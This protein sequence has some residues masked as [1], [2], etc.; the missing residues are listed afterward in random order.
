MKTNVKSLILKSLV[1]CVGLGLTA[2]SSDEVVVN[3]SESTVMNGKYIPSS[4]AAQMDRLVYIDNNQM[5]FEFYYYGD[6]LYYNLYHFGLNQELPI[7]AKAR[8]PVTYD[9]QKSQS[10]W[11]LKLENRRYF[12]NQTNMHLISSTGETLY[13]Q[14][15][16]LPKLDYKEIEITVEPIPASGG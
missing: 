16:I 6:K 10:T 13:P 1:L 8:V 2:C 9:I 15:V 7:R 3:K 11:V 12:L 4:T 5:G 14:R